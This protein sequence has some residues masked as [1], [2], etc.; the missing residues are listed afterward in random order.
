MVN[1]PTKVEGIKKTYQVSKKHKSNIL[2]KSLKEIL[3]NITKPGFKFPI[4]STI[5]WYVENVGS[6]PTYPIFYRNI[7]AS[8]NKRF[9]R[10]KA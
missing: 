8:N 9:K 10:E 3:P 1:I 5:I 6:N 7:Y 4:W 2:Y